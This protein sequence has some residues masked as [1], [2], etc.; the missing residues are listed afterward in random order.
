MQGPVF[1]VSRVRRKTTPTPK[2]ATLHVKEGLG[3]NGLAG[4]REGG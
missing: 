4:E 2:E 3:Q 1:E